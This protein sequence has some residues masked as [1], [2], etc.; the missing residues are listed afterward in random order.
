MPII[1]T[2]LL[3]FLLTENVR[4]S[5]YH[6]SLL[7]PYLILPRLFTSLS[8]YRIHY[9][10]SSIST[11]FP[12]TSLAIHLPGSTSSVQMRNQS[13]FL[14]AF[15][16]S[17]HLF[18]VFLTH[19]IQDHVFLCGQYSDASRSCISSPGFSSVIHN[20]YRTLQGL[21]PVHSL[22]I[23][24]HLTYQTQLFLS[25]AWPTNTPFPLFSS[26]RGIKL[27]SFIILKLKGKKSGYCTNFM[28]FSPVVNGCREK[29][30][31]QTYPWATGIAKWWCGHPQRCGSILISS[32]LFHLCFIISET[33]QEIWQ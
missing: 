17:H 30:E 27:P 24:G 15:F 9:N 22:V 18:T 29:S 12:P 1:S 5:F 32:F 10:H 13:Q 6:P 28:A 14:L 8:S 19:P 23:A 7:F 33:R 20:V 26:Y 21:S 2:I 11:W 16:L 31:Q 25:W 3:S 4:L